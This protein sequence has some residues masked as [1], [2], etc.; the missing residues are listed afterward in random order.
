M[1][2]CDAHCDTLYNLVT[3]PGEKTDLTMDRLIKGGV[4]LQTM[5][6]YVGPKATQQEVDLLMDN[7]LLAF[8]ELKSQGWTQAFDPSEAEEDT[9][10][11]M[12]SIEGCE[13]FQNGL[14]AIARF[15]EK[16]VRMAAIVWNHSNDLATSHLV[17]AT[18]G[19]TA[20]GLKAIKEMQRLG[21]A[22]DVSHLNEAG[23]WDIL[24]KTDR[25]PVAS[26]SC[27]RALCD[28]TRNLTDEQLKAM[29]H[30]GGWV[31]VNFFPKFLSSSGHATLDTVVDH[32][33]H[34]YQ[35][36]GAG[37]VGFGSDFDGIGTKPE[38]L[39]NPEDFPGL[40]QKLRDR[41]YRDQDVKDIAGQAFINYY[42]RI[43]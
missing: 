21:I 9:V 37:Q 5:A 7:M 1:I 12:L 43:G 22:P 25:P 24:N 23:F 38:G 39:D 26:H 35:V 29:F 31:G 19:L 4:N 34:M 6:M 30:A 18:T 42:K 16:G 33:D 11:F 41:G 27:A 8:E 32:I 13:P 2:L 14:H 40:I 3:K 28:H 10:K 36:G 17:D 20:F 15:R